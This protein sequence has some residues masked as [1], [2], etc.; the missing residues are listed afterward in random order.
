MSDLAI[1]VYRDNYTGG[2]QIAIED[3]DGGYRLAGPKFI[4]KSELLK[5]A[6]L[7]E[8]VDF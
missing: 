3:E 6:I 7:S 4:G 8:L 2:T 5:R 1:N